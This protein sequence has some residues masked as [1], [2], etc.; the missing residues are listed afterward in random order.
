MKLYNLLLRFAYWLCIMIA[1]HLGRARGKL[2]KFI[3]GQAG[4]LSL[5]EEGERADGGSNPVI[6]VHASSLGEFGIARPIIRLLKATG[7]YRIVVT[8]F[9]STGIE[10]LRYHHNDVDAVYYLPLDTPANVRRFMAAIR[11]SK[12][13]F[14]KSEYWL[15]YLMWLREHQIP[16]YLVS[17][18]ITRKAPFF[19]PVYGYLYRKAL[20]TYSQILVLDD[21][22]RA[23]LAEIGFDRVQ[24]TGDP[25]FDNVITLAHTPYS[26]TVIENF[27]RGSK[28]FVAGSI[29]DK[30]DAKMV[31]KLANRH[32]DVRFI[33]VPHE[34][35][36]DN[37]EAIMRRLK[38][39]TLRYSESDATTSME[40][41]QN[42]IIDFLGSLAY[43]YRFGQWA[44]VGGGFTPYLHSIVEPTAYGLPV[45]FGP[46]V[47]R[48][49]TPLQLQALGVAEIVRTPNELDNWFCSLKDNVER[50]DE[51][52]RLNL[53]YMTRN[54]GATK[55]IVEAIDS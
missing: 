14:I 40:G 30:K 31:V 39:Q 38:G 16:T 8:F 18:L 7:K 47:E 22:S 34:I 53:S 1:P 42:L 17:A 23:N 44:Y 52:R 12:A 11:P 49:V 35:S 2:A 9:S 36:V 24:V 32:P 21:E 29:H 15:N 27:V 33:I 45:S 6:W 28:V 41:V 25:L 10:A 43:I 5:A 13:V 4:V 3:V 19:K 54:E 26:N 51:I 48:K 55:K 20:D 37:V 46:R 50:L